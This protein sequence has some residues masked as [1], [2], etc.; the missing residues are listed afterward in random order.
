MTLPVLYTDIILNI[1]K[2][3]KNKDITILVNVSIEPIKAFDRVLYRERN[4]S[5]ELINKLYRD[6]Y[7]KKNDKSKYPNKNNLEILSEKVDVYLDID[8]NKQDENFIKGIENKKLKEKVYLDM[9][10]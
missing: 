5:K 9:I 8:N 6:I 4:V 10:F 1:L 2:T 3:Q 7:D